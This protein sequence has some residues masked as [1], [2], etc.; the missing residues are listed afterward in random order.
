MQDSTGAKLGASNEECMQQQFEFLGLARQTIIDFAHLKSVV[1]GMSERVT[2]VEK[3]VHELDASFNKELSGMKEDQK[4]LL[5]SFDT[6]YGPVLEAYNK[7]KTA[8][9]KAGTVAIIYAVASFL[10]PQLSIPSLSSIIKIIF[11]G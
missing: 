9:A 11:G 4:K 2:R 5:E 10:V 6:K 3:N 1:E 8:W 7:G